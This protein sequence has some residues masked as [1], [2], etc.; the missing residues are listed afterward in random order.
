V[1][2]DWHAAKNDQNIDKHGIAF[3]VAVQVFAANPLYVYRTDRH[4][5]E[6]Y[7]AVGMVEGR[8][9]AVAFTDRI[10][11]HLQLRRI[12]SARR[13]QDRERQAYD[14]QGR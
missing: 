3:D 7:T 14:A 8:L 4:A 2:F 10:V 12:I 5:E 6:R 1:R 13:A 11:N 9:L